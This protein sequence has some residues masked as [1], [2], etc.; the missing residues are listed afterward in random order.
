MIRTY[1]RYC[2]ANGYCLKR[3]NRHKIKKN[4][5]KKVAALQ[6]IITK[7]IFQEMDFNDEFL[8]QKFN[9]I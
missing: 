3:I 6:V 4:V 8:T 5:L 2:N 9:F 1:S 7:L